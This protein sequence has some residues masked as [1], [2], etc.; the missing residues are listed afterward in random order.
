MKKILKKIYKAILNH[1]VLMCGGTLEADS[2]VVPVSIANA[3][4]AVGDLLKWGAH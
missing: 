4:P 1:D 2:S 3:N